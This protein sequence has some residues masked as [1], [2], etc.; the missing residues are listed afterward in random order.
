MCD[1]EEIVGSLG[2]LPFGRLVCGAM[3]AVFKNIE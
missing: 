1:H 2:Q 3:Q